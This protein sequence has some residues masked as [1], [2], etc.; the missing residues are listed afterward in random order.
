MSTRLKA[1]LT[2]VGIAVLASPVIAPAESSA[3]QVIIRNQG[4]AP[5]LRAARPSASSEERHMHVW[6]CGH[7]GFPQCSGGQ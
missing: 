3:Q 1:T 2:A 6:D 7:S 5:Y 4:S